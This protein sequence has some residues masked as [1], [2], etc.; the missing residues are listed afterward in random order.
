M[1]KESQNRAGRAGRGMKPRKAS[2]PAPATIGCRP[3]KIDATGERRSCSQNPN[4]TQPIGQLDFHPLASLFQLLGGAEFEALVED[5]HEHGVREPVGT[6]EGKILDG[7]NRWRTAQAAGVD[8]PFQEYTGSDPVSLVISLNLN[9]RQLNE[10]QRAMIAVQLAT[11]PHGGNRSKAPNDALKD[12][13]EAKL[14]NVAERSVER[15]KTV[16]S[17]PEARKALSPLIREM[18]DEAVAAKKANSAGREVA[19]GAKQLALP[20][21]RTNPSAT[22]QNMAACQTGTGFERLLTASEAANFLHVSPSWLAKSRMRSDGPPF[23][24]FGRCVRYPE[25]TL[26]QWT[27]SHFPRSTSD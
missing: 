22:Q 19:A 7:R 25:E 23:V 4:P 5:I 2:R 26:A 18:R 12:A 1:S 27:R 10:G 15:A 20:T 21:K 14:L 16:R 8:C 6:Y 9:R 3:R 13:D 11:L 24:K 17:T